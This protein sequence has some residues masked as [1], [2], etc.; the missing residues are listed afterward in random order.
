LAHIFKG[1]YTAQIEGPFVVFL[2]GMRIN[3]L[4]AVHK[5]WPAATAM[6]PMIAE[7]KAQPDSGLLHAEAYAYWRGAAVVQYWRS[8]EALEAYSR[9]AGSRH[10][11][12]WKA[13]NRVVGASG[14][15]GIWHETFIVQ[16]RQ[17]ECVY[18]NMPRRGLGW[19][20]Q[21]LV[22]TGNRDTAKRRLGR[23]GEPAVPSYDTPAE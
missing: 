10:L 8:F 19:A 4:W 20:G 1:R 12:A 14:T 15:V 17:Y 18:G 9:E 21:H 13:F 3:R 6:G 2:I 7:L 16:A 23:Q 5:W 11:P 22:A